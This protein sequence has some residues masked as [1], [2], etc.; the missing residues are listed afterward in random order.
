MKYAAIMLL[1]IAGTA[2]AASFNCDKAATFVEKTICS[3]NSLSKLDDALAENY[4]HMMA[5]DIGKGARM[6]LRTTEREW[7]TMRNK[8]TTAQC[9]ETLYRQRVDAVCDYPVISGLHP[10]CTSADD[11]LA[12]SNGARRAQAAQPAAQLKAVKIKPTVQKQQKAVT[13][14]TTAPDDN[15]DVPKFVQYGLGAVGV[16]KSDYDELYNILGKS[17]NGFHGLRQEPNNPYA[18]EVGSCYFVLGVVVQQV[19]KTLDL[20]E[21]YSIA[22]GKTGYYFAVSFL[23]NS[24]IIRNG[25][26][27]KL[28]YSAAEGDLVIGVAVG[29]APFKYDSPDGTLNTVPNFALIFY[30]DAGPGNYN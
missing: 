6:D 16:S 3:N 21:Y 29:V 24:S 15:S 27:D 10:D 4:K 28:G 2:S 19:S 17:C 8:C 1:A 5:S 9:I 20:V 7:L 11:A 26:Y 14:V 12:V 18:V 13:S 22:G 25:K 30:K 23:P